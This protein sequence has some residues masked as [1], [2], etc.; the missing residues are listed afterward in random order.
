MTNWI[1]RLRRPLGNFFVLFGVAGLA[2]GA[3]GAL[4]LV[5]LNQVLQQELEPAIGRMHDLTVDAQE[6]LVAY[7]QALGRTIDTLETLESASHSAADT[8]AVT[9][10]VLGS[11]DGLLSVD[12]PSVLT[13]T[14]SAL[15]SAGRSADV[16]DFVLG[17]LNAIAQLTG[18][19][20]EPTLPL[21]EA[22]T[23][24][25]DSLSPIQESL[26]DVSADLVTARQNLTPL[27]E[28]MQALETGLADIG[29]ALEDGHR[30]ISRY[31]GILNEAELALAAAQE[32]APRLRG[33]V[34]LVLGL[35]LSWLAMSQLALLVQG[36]QMVAFD[37]TLFQ[38]RLDA[39]EAKVK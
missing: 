15:E 20:Y 29:A 16:I 25:Q 11:V 33:R 32:G 17:G 8:L 14:V 19:S 1:T 5:R 18:V 37:P 36:A 21:G 39:L 10:S 9:D 38:S 12:L 13:D 31:E 30:A 22:I 35:A 26:T 28:D 23:N 24:V 7:Q 34:I 6:A 27:R 2:I 3:L 4:G